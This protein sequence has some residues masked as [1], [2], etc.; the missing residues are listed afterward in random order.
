M[1]APYTDDPVRDA[2]CYMKAL[3]QESERWY[4]QYED[5]LKDFSIFQMFLQELDWEDPSWIAIHKQLNQDHESKA[6]AYDIMM[7]MYEQ[8]VEE[9]TEMFH[10]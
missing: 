7:Q 2:E 1:N 5:N 4:Q 8:F 6:F 3:E 10:E 9:Y